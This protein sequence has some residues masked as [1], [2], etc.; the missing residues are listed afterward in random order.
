MNPEICPV[1][2]ASRHSEENKQEESRDIS[3]S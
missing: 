3:K 2:I 1:R